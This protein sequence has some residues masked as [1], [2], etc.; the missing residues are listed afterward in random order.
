MKRA[1][2]MAFSALALAATA[3]AQ[4]R[5]TYIDLVKRLT[6]LEYLATLPAPGETTAQWSSYDRASKYDEKSGKYVRW[7]ANGDGDGIIRKE[8]GKLVLAEM[9]GPGCIWRIWSAAP[10]EGHV[11]IYLDGASEPAVDLPFAG[12][13]DG[14][15]EPFTRPA[16]VHTVAHGWNNYTPIPYQKSCKIV[17]DR[18]WGQYYHFIYTTFPKGTQVPTFK[19]ELAPEENAALDEANR[20]LSNC[21]PREFPERIRKQRHGQSAGAASARRSK[22]FQD[23]IEGPRRSPASARSSIPPTHRRDR[24]ALRELTLQIRWDGES[25]ASVW[26]PLGDFFGTAPGANP[27]R[28]L[29][30]GHDGGRLVVCELV[31]AVRARAP[32]WS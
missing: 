28:S 30:C 15:N 29:P 25:A 14:K 26:A 9:Q 24:D 8:D 20:I 6:D 1:T 23:R 31:H 27:Y 17:A 2:L 7:D 16:L 13:F 21:G 3:G 22:V 19:R 10:K 32:R 18:G 12:Y 11:R 5:L 4:P